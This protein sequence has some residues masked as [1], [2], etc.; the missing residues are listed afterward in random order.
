MKE[1]TI[2]IYRSKNHPLNQVVMVRY[3]VT[4]IKKEDN[5]ISMALTYFI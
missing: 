4:P 5:Q 1:S 2:V 3:S